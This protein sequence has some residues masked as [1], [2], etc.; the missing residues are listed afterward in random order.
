M[1]P[2]TLT[3]AAIATLAF[4]KAIEKTAETLTATVLNK[5]NNLREKIWQRFRDNPKLDETLAKAKKEG[6][7]ADVDLISAHLQYEMDTDP[8]F[9]Q[10]IQQL[11]QEINQEI[12]IDKIEGRN[13]QNVYGGEAFQ[14]ND[15]NAPTFQGGSGH[16]ITINYN[17]PN[18]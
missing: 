1:E 8:K 17:N 10:D 11:A 18:S 14:A 7:K 6:A 4:S 9:A 5:L 12:N 15:A 13:V 16:S 3:A 2:A